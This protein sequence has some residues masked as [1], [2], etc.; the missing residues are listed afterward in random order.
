MEVAIIQLLKL[1]F[2]TSITHFLLGSYISTILFSGNLVQTTYNKK[3][4]TF[5]RIFEQIK[6]SKQTS[7]HFFNV[8]IS[9]EILQQSS[10][11]TSSNCSSYAVPSVHFSN[12]NSRK[13]EFTRQ[14][15]PFLENS[16]ILSL[17]SLYHQVYYNDLMEE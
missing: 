12:F 2:F 7:V 1:F 5:L 4:F 6:Q 9:V 17:E 13:H 14:H 10:L 8:F 15:L 11:I 3:F 16:G